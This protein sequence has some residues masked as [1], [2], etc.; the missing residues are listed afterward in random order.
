MRISSKSL[1]LLKVISGKI[2][3]QSITNRIY[4]VIKFK[5]PNKTKQNKLQIIR[6]KALKLPTTVT[7]TVIMLIY[8]VAQDSIKFRR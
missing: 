7:K 6:K 2:G 5:L 1:T 3:S 8:E 4:M